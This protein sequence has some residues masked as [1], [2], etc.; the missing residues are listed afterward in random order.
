MMTTKKNSPQKKVVII[1][2]GVAGIAT[3]VFLANKGFQVEVYEKNAA[4]GGRCGQIFKNGH[5]FDLGATILLMPSVY[6]DVFRSL[7]LDMDK[8]LEPV[9]LDPIYKLFF[10][11][12]SDFSYSPNE[13]KMKSQLEAFEPD[14]YAQYKRYVKKGYGF[15]RLATE[16]LL[17]RNFYHLREFLTLRNAAMM[18]HFKTWIKHTV[19][20]RRFFKDARLQKVFTFQNIYVG[21]NPYRQPAFFSMIPSAEIMEGALFPKGGMHTIVQKLMEKAEEAGVRFHFN[22]NVE[23]IILDGR[24]AKGIQLSN[25]QNTYADIVVANA[26]L[27]YVYRYLLPDRK[28]SLQ[29]ERKEYSCSAIVF[30]WAMDQEYPQLAHHSI[31]LNEPYKE[32]MEMIFDKKS[33]SSNPSF[34][35]HSP[36]RTDKDAAPDKQD[37]LSV[38]I[39]A[40]HIDDGMEQDWDLL[41]KR[42]RIAVFKRLKEAGID[43]VEKHIKFE[44]CVM[45]QTW[46]D[47]CNITN[48]AVFGSLSHTIFQMGYFRPHNRHAKYTNLFFVGGSTHPGNGVPLVLLSSKLTTERILKETR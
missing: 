33:L 12:G 35:I 24:K 31:F 15:F 46:K 29:L 10:S 36:V 6:R 17:G 1:G 23:N 42:A 20:I 38:I 41:K 19:Y 3:S 47:Y 34:Y 18:I 27:P 11:D 48:G 21:Q 5:R 25:G 39:P 7:G 44:I 40:P 9:S 26:D 22:Q 8:E 13:A 28:A 30:H 45:P 2:A 16:Q 14:S 4:P 32:G 43:D 37:S